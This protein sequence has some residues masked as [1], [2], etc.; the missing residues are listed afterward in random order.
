MSTSASKARQF[1]PKE[2][3]DSVRALTLVVRGLRVG[4][5]VTLTD[6]TMVRSVG[7]KR[8]LGLER[9]FS[10]ISPGSTVLERHRKISLGYGSV[11]S[12]E[13]AALQALGKTKT[14]SRQ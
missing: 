9:K 7:V 3:L 1:D 5:R 6:G 10:V 13:E 14:E 12:A 2:H 8:G 11:S 4:E